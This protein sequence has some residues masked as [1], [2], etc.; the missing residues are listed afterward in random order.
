[1]ITGYEKCITYDINVWKRSWSTRDEASQTIAKLG[2]TPKK[3]LLYVWW[4]WK[5]IVH[6]ELLSPSKTDSDLYCQQLIRYDWSD[7]FKKSGQNWS[8]KRTSSIMTTPNHIFDSA[9]IEREF[10][11]KVLMLLTLHRQITFVSIFAEFP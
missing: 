8:I 11:W 6:Y 1:L 4:N 10:G 2:L 7:Q 5:G 3:V 9:K